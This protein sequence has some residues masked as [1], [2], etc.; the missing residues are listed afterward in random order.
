[1]G[2]SW[3]R[4][5][6]CYPEPRPLWQITALSP[7]ATLDHFAGDLGIPSESG[8]LRIGISCCFLWILRSHFA[9][10]QP[11]GVYTA[12]FPFR[13]PNENAGARRVRARPRM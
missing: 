4:C 8:F 6:R 5:H 1:M 9:N 10:K 11:V 2:R 3:G 13:L 7:F 12:I